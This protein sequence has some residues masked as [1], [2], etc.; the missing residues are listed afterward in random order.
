[1]KVL[2]VLSPSGAVAV[3]GTQSVQALV[4]IDG[5][6]PDD[7]QVQLVHGPVGGA[8]DLA[9]AAVVPMTNVGTGDGGAAL[10]EG[11]FTCTSV[12]RYGFTVRVLPYHPGLQ[13]PVE[14]GRIAWA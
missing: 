13:S 12:G 6:S 10:Y 4:D 1:V 7:V 9:R 8:D 5:L 11:S 3:G 14:L 2:E